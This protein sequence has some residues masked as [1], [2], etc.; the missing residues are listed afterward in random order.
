MR[1][2]KNTFVAGLFLVAGLVLSVM[3]FVDTLN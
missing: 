1:F 3:A 2:S